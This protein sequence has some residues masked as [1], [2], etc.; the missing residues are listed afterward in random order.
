MKNLFDR[1]ITILKVQN[2]ITL[3][4]ECGNVVHR[5]RPFHGI[6]FNLGTVE[7]NYRFSGGQ[8]LTA[9][10]N[11]MIYMPKYSSYDVLTA[12]YGNCIAVNLSLLED[13]PFLPLKAS[14]ESPESIL[15]LFRM[16]DRIWNSKRSGYEL[17]TQS[18]LYDILYMMHCSLNIKKTE[19]K[20]ARVAE[21]IENN[22][23]KE[24]PRISD[25]AEMAHMSEDY[26]RKRFGE[27]YKVSPLQ[28]VHKLRLK[29][30]TELLDSDP[31]AIKD[32]AAMCGYEDENYF[33]RKF[34][35]LTGQTP[36][37]YKKSI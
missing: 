32:I 4:A 13:G 11:E 10:Q 22:Y 5:N 24:T 7:K 28:Y 16:A 1:D 33:S 6:M 15:M 35:Q 12:S 36:R 27:I 14:A 34:K 30:A 23:Y 25:L 19:N 21:Y 29:R 2:V 8:T 26:F 17:K 9:N 20:M 18:I 37:E 31:Y 3:P